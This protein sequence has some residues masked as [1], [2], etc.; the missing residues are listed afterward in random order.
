MVSTARRPWQTRRNGSGT[1]PLALAQRRHC[2][3][4]WAVESTSTPSRSKR[5]PRHSKRFMASEFTV[6]VME[7]GRLLRQAGLDVDPGQTATFLRALSLIGLD[8]RSDVRVAGRTIFVRR[9]EDR[10]LYD[11]AFD[12][13]WRRTGGAHQLEG[14]LPRISQSAQRGSASELADQAYPPGSREVTTTVAVRA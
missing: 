12:L 6:N 11:A 9:F 8:G 1:R 10:A 5:I 4:T 2:S 3:S 14:Q 7:F 13:F